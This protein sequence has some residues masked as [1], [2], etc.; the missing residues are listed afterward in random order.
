[1]F[2]FQKSQEV[3]KIG[4]TDF[5]GQPGER[6][7]VLVLPLR[8]LGHE[9]IDELNDIID[10]TNAGVPIASL[11]DPSESDANRQFDAAISLKDV[12]MIIG[13][14]ENPWAFDLVH[15]AKDIGEL[16]RLI[17]GGLRITTDDAVWDRVRSSGLRSVILNAYNP[18][19]PS[20]KGRIYTI[21]GGGGVIEEGLLERAEKYGIINTLLDLGGPD[22]PESGLRALFVAKAKW[23]LP[24]T[25]DLGKVI[26]EADHVAAVTL[27]QSAGADFIIAGRSELWGSLLRTLS[28]N[29]SLI[30]HAV[31]ER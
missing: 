23:G 31:R 18:E 28:F 29:D 2:K 6:R 24:C 12:P 21:E 7:T 13:S 10:Q 16:D 15:R 11:I 8:S 1:M 9:G 26:N 25:I 19:D 14:A 3:I 5:G 27:M 17:L 4:K 20:L 22:K 30:S